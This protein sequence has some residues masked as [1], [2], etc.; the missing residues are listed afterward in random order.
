MR[1]KAAREPAIDRARAEAIAA[2]GLAFLAEDAGKLG[3]FLAET[4]LEVDD[5]R[6]N[7]GSADMLQ[8]VLDY[9]NSNEPLLLVFAGSRGMK[10][11][12]IALAH[13]VLQGRG[14]DD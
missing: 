14:R 3:H 10:P 6:A 2:E 12:A 1:F 11:E 5:L 9:L 13:A 4:G 7:A 8:A